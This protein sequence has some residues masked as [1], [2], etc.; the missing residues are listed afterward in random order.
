MKKLLVVSIF[1]VLLGVHLSH[2]YALKLAKSNDIEKLGKASNII[3]NNAAIY[4]KMGLHYLR[5]DSSNVNLSNFLSRKIYES[6]GVKNSRPYIAKAYEMNAYDRYIGYIYFV[7]EYLNGR[8][9]EKR[10]DEVTTSEE[11]FLRAY[12]KEPINEEESAEWYSFLVEKKPDVLDSKSFYDLKN[13]NAYIYEKSIWM[14]TQR[15]IAQW[16]ETN[17]PLLQ[18]KIAKLMMHN[19]LD[20]MADEWF[21]EVIERVPSLNRAYFYKAQMLMANH[22]TVA[23]R[24]MLIKSTVLDRMDPL[25]KYYL[26]NI[27]S[28]KS[29]EEFKCYYK[30]PIATEYVYD[31]KMG[32]NAEVLV[33]LVDYIS[34]KIDL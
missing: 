25:P 11:L 22:D 10:F 28:H 30:T 3:S 13:R 16:R 17:D 18:S 4:C 5:D 32:E 15:M 31:V 33:G 29:G 1:I 23:A 34:P 7:V 8:F 14:A 9:I 20:D 21:T 27:E 24:D 2:V 12:I 26:E 19:G 6:S